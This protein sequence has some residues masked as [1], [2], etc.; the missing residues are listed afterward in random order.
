LLKSHDQEL[1]PE[2]LLEIR[3]QSGLEEAEEPEPEE[4]TATGFGVT[5]AGDELFV[6]IDW[7]KERA[8]ATGTG[9]MGILPCYEVILKEMKRCLSARHRCLV[10]SRQLQGLTH[11]HLE[12]YMFEK[13]IQMTCL[14]FKRKCLLFALSLA[15]HIFYFGKYLGITSCFLD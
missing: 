1:K 12:C 6:G 9:V 4:R 14:Q 13:M 11:H 5:V 15:C 7:N 2:D 8:A 10:S 3:K